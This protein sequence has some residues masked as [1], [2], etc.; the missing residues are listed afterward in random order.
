LHGFKSFPEKTV[1][2]FHKGITAIVGPNGCGKSNL[3]DAILWVLGEQRIKNLRGENNEDLI[4]NGSSSKKPL[5]MTEVGAF[6]LNKENETYIGRRFFRSGEGKYILNEKF[7]RNKDIQDTLFSLGIGEKGYFIFEQGSIEKIITF[8]P[9]ERR[10]LIEEAAGIVQYLER[11]KDTASKL[12]ISQQNLDNLEIILL[13]KERRLKELK[14]QVHFAQRYRVVKNQKTDFLKA[15]LKSKYLSHKK[16]FDQ[17]AEGVTQQIN[18]ETGLA[19]DIS[20]FEEKL[21]ALEQSRWNLDRS[22][23]TNQQKLFDLNNQILAGSKE[24]EKLQQRLGFLNQKMEELQALATS[25]LSETAEFDERIGAVEKENRELDRQHGEDEARTKKLETEMTAARNS[26]ASLNARNGRLRESTFALEV[27]ISRNSNEINQMEKSLVRL[28]QEILNKVHLL[29][30]LEKEGLENEI[31]KAND[32]I[33]AAEKLWKDKELL[34][35]A[36][37]DE[38]QDICARAD[39]MEKQLGRWNGEVENLRNQKEKYAQVKQKMVGGDRPKPGIEYQGLLPD[40]IRTDKKYHR[41]LE[42]FYYEEMDAPLLVRDADALDPDI[43]K[44]LIKRENKS[45]FADAIRQEAGFG[46]FVKNLYELGDRSLKA[47]FK[48]GV[49]VDRL[50]NGIRIFMKYGVD[51]VT[52]NGEIISRDGIL[53]KHR[54]RGILEIQE[55]IKEIDGK[56]LEQG[57]AIE[58]GKTELG[59]MLK[60]KTEMSVRQQREK[61]DLLALKERLIAL[62]FR[63]ENLEKSQKASRNRIQTT[64]SEKENLGGEEGRLQERLAALKGEKEKLDEQRKSQLAQREEFRQENEAATRQ[65]NEIEKSKMQQD[66]LLQIIKEKLDARADTL[67]ELRSQKAKRE[68]QLKSAGQETLHLRSESTESAEKIERIRKE[69]AALRR[70]KGEFENRIKA[71]EDELL[72]VNAGIKETSAKLAVQRGARDECREAKKEQEIR[73]ASVKK[74]LFQ[75]EEASSQEIGV[76]LKDIEADE[77]LLARDMG[78]IES[79]LN[80]LSAKLNRMRDSDR[81]NFSAEAEYEILDKDYRFLVTQKEDIVKS[82]QD[83]SAAMIKIDNESKESFMKAFTRINENFVKNFKILFEGGEAQLALSD[84]ENVLEAGLEIQA[85]PPGKRLQSL[86]LLSGGEKA[87]TSLAFLFAL[88]EYKPSP[89]CVFDEVDA[90]LDEANVQRYLNFVTK[91][92]EKTQFVI[93]THNFKTMEKADYVYGISMDEPGISKIFSMKLS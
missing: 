11:K 60:R 54:D 64:L 88:F 21:V 90:S 40:L 87:L 67:K 25:G 2:Q 24:I 91:L 74:D 13:D 20:E 10:V 31:A 26:L 70:Q 8:K 53:I 14:N 39:G 66:H 18:R 52:E 62:R 42:N 61:A 32:E 79:E 35:K 16:E 15:F 43:R 30:E 1:M 82:I 12:V 6:F 49:L 51:V 81:L 50:E 73:L 34:V 86:R 22:L 23:K 93:I 3:V 33:R 83:M 80:E 9:S 78:E 68:A 45:G 63:L 27:N 36:G 75:L 37:D 85:Q 76:E 55:E 72:K 59:Q 19:K 77:A 44:S 57:R 48:D 84:L 7:C 17:F 56:I 4:F 92:K 41:I 58:T 89:F 46:D 38:Y 29:Q 71:E 5:G 47:Y 69:A 65:I 28:E